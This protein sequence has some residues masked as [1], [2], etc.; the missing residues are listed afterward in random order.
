M[1]RALQL[2]DKFAKI[3]AAH[4]ADSPAGELVEGRT[5]WRSPLHASR[6]HIRGSMA[7]IAQRYKVPGSITATIC[8]PMFVMHLQ[9]YTAVLSLIATTTATMFVP[10]D[11][12]ASQQPPPI[13]LQRIPFPTAH[14][15]GNNERNQ[16]PPQPPKHNGVVPQW[17]ATPP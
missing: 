3:L 11:N 1:S 12:G 15:Q 7:T 5:C 14:E 4:L 13:I 8:H 6:F 9:P 10:L 16:A 2:M 17:P